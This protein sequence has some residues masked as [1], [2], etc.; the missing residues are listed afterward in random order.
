MVTT[1]NK[2]S[3][4]TFLCE[5]SWPDKRSFFGHQFCDFAGIHFESEESLKVQVALAMEWRIDQM[6]PFN[7]T[8][9]LTSSL[10]EQGI[11]IT[12]TCS[13]DTM[14]LFDILKHGEDAICQERITSELIPRCTSVLNMTRVEGNNNVQLQCS[15][16]P[17]QCEENRFVDTSST[18][19]LRL[20][21]LTVKY[22]IM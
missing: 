2:E 12:T 11:T 14:Q 22:N 3:P 17:K 20:Q 16:R 8:E 7:S 4:A 9:E 19:Y 13:F 6:G 18:V 5:A 21:G 1:L 15:V 10:T